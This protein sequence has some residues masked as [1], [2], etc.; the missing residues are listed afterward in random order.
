MITCPMDLSGVEWTC[1]GFRADRWAADQL[2]RYFESPRCKQKS[3]TKFLEKMEEEGQ[4]INAALE[5]AGHAG[6]EQGW[7]HWR[8]KSTLELH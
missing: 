4:E 5:K 8:L 2:Y 3:T 6:V 7:K 1:S